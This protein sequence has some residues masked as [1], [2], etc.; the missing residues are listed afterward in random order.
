[1]RKWLQEFVKHMI[2]NKIKLVCFDID[3][4]LTD[5]YVHIDQ[6]GKE[7]KTFRLTEIDALNDIKLIGLKIAAITGENTQIVNVFR[8]KA[9]WDFFISGCKN[10]LEAVKQIQNQVC[11]SREEFCYIGDGKYDIPAIKYAGLGVCPSNA[12]QEAKEA[13][14]IVLDG[15]GGES[16]VY[17]LYTLLRKMKNI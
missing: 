5:G 15:A 16:C 4:I 17:E 9:N 11:L 10:K 14:D 1:M 8:T 2:I 12:I 13:A 6:E 3:G 7:Y